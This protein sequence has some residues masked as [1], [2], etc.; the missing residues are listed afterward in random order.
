MNNCVGYLIIHAVGFF[1]SSL[2]HGSGGMKGRAAMISYFL[3]V[4]AK[5]LVLTVLY[6][7]YETREQAKQENNHHGELR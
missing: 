6:I 3:T 2:N 4:T 1:L 5:I 7:A